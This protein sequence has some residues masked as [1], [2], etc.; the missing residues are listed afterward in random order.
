[1]RLPF[2]N[3]IGFR[4]PNGIAH[5]PISIRIRFILF[6]SILVSMTAGQKEAGEYFAQ[7][8]RHTKSD[9]ELDFGKTSMQAI[10]MSE[11]VS[12]SIESLLSD[13]DIAPSELQSHPEILEKILDS[14]FERL[15]F[16]LE[17][18]GTSA[19]HQG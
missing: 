3:R 17:K 14:Q 19:Y 1:M 2:A 6:V 18:S 15:I 7:S 13:F 5:M 9:I 12:S 8:L 16:S 4:T 10:D 11:T